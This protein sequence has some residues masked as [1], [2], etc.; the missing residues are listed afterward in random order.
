MKY[1]CRAR[2]FQP[3]AEF[4]LTGDG[5][6]R[7]TR[8]G[9]TRIS[10]SDIDAIDV[11]KERRFGSSRSYWASTIAAGVRKFHLTAAHR[12]SLI[13]TED[14]TPNYIPFIKEFERRA[15]AAKPELRFTVDEYRETLA[16]KIYGRVALWS[17]VPLSLLSRRKSAAV[18]A[19]VFRLVGPMLKG[20]RYA[21]AQ[22][23][24]AMPTLKPRETRRIL[25]GMW[26]N[27]GR[28]FGEYPHIT[29]LMEFSLE[30]P[31]AGQVIMDEGTAATL[32]SILGNGQGTLLFAAHLGNFE[33]PAMAARA[34][35]RDI[36]LV[37]KR[38]PSASL[39]EE[40][41]RKR[42]LIAAR[43]IEARPSALGEIIAA[44]RN[45]Q[46]VGMLVDQHYEAGIEVEFFGRACKVNPVLALLNRRGNWPIYGARAVRLPDQRHRIE[47]VGP[48]Q[49]SRD[50]LGEVDTPATMQ[51]IIGLIETWIREE[52]AQW[53]WMHRLIRPSVSH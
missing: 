47:V 30:K 49:I 48:L 18:C 17:I 19:A 20:H 42:A 38:Q 51:T 8:F 31:R 10:F 25:R 37:Y 6:T 28:T 11:F 40:I 36:V 4:E 27:I 41:K 39:T 35:G 7:H 44:L 29:E 32:R 23:T 43:L 12:A 3:P 24:A 53:M 22:L 1:S 52:P 13:Q 16:T 34:I 15:I 33:V 46:L 21:W 50:A 26:D 45:G 2:L 5:L 9:A 14:R